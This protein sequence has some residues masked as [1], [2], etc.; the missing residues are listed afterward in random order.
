MHNKAHRCWHKALPCSWGMVLDKV[1]AQRAHSAQDDLIERQCNGYKKELSCKC[2]K[3]YYKKQWTVIH[4]VH[5]SLKGTI[6]SG[7]ILML[8]IAIGL[9]LIFWDAQQSTH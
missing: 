3:A 6:L 7:T 1:C 2:G 8:S 9:P 5:M 4:K